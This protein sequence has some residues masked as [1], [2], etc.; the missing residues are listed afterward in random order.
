MSSF[1]FFDTNVLVY[2]DDAESR[3]KQNRTVQQH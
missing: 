2:F 1:A 3:E